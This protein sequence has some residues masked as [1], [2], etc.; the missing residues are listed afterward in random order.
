[1][2]GFEIAGPVIAAG[3]AEKK[4]PRGLLVGRRGGPSRLLGAR[5]PLFA[6]P[7][8]QPSTCLSTVLN[9]AFSECVQSHTACHGCRLYNPPHRLT[10]SVCET[11]HTLKIQPISEKPAKEAA[12]KPKMQIEESQAEGAT[13]CLSF[14]TSFPPSLPPAVGSVSLPTLPTQL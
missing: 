11:Q 2:M 1:M 10:I 14:P 5:I 3:R 6:H 12:T 8:A 4:R 9:L 13:V 7:P